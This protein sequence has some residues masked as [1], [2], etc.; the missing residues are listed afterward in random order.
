MLLLHFKFSLLRG[1]EVCLTY[2][3]LIQCLNISVKW[4]VC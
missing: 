1:R 4:V 3:G 2:Q